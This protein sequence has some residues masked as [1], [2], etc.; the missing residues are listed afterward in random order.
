MRKWIC[1]MILVTGMLSLTACGTREDSDDFMLQTVTEAKSEMDQETETADVTEEAQKDADSEMGTEETQTDMESTGIVAAT[2]ENIEN[3][4]KITENEN[5]IETET[6]EQLRQEEITEMKVEVNGYI[7]YA[8]LEKNNA[9]TELV[10]MMREQ[11]VV[12]NMSDYSGF[13]KVGSLGSTLSSSNSQ[14]TTKAGDIV[15]YNSNQIV[16]FYGSN[17][18]SYT[19]IGH[20]TDLTGWKEALGAGDVTITF[21]ID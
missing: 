5:R 17:S 18:W 12:I 9:V 13:E 11:P 20:I 10:E 19:R 6:Q 2:S 16:V 4:D 21:S 7:F 1:F 8:T 15:L 3:N 14:T